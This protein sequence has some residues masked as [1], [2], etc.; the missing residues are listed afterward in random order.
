M[1]T[2][3][4]LGLTAPFAVY[5][6]VG[7]GA[8]D[9]AY[10]HALAVPRNSGAQNRIPVLGPPT[11]AHHA[12]EAVSTPAPQRSPGQPGTVVV[13]SPPGSAVADIAAAL[14]ESVGG[15]HVEPTDLGGI[16]RACAGARHVALVALAG[17]IGERE[18]AAAQDSLWQE[19]GGG[20]GGH[21]GLLTGVTRAD[22]AWLIAKGL[23]LPHRSAP[24]DPAL[25]VWSALES[26]ERRVSSRVLLAEDSRTSVLRPLL[27]EQRWRDLSLM[28]HGRDDAAIFNDM[29]VCA[30]GPLRLEPDDPER[31]RAPACAFTGRCYRP[32]VEPDQVVKAELIL[33][34]AVFAN[35]CMSLRV[36]DGL[37]PARYLLPHGF[38]R[39]TAAGFIGSPMVVNGSAKLADVFHACSAGG[40]TL[41][42]TATVMN[43][44]LRHERV[45]LP[46]FTMLGLPW[47]RLADPDPAAWDAFAQ[48][49][50]E[51][52]THWG[53]A[54]ATALSLSAETRTGR[55]LVLATSPRS[56]AALAAVPGATAL[57]EVDADDVSDLSA[58]AR[59]L[60]RS[61]TNLDDVPL[62][63]L[64]Y[65][66]HGNVMNNVRAQV[67]SLA[68]ALSRAALAGDIDRLTRRLD[69]VV[70]AVER[71]ELGL[72]EALA[73]RGV[74][75]IQ[76]FNDIWG[77]RFE[78]DEP[79]LSG[80]DCPYCGRALV[81][82][83]AT[84]S[85][86]GRLRRT[87]TICPRCVVVIDSD[88]AS[89]VASARLACEESWSRDS[90]QEV[91]LTFRLGPGHAAGSTV[92]A[93]VFV[94]GAE[95]IG[96]GAAAVE[97]IRPDATGT[98]RLTVKVAVGQEA[99]L[100]QEY[101]RGLVIAEGTVVVVTR[102][103]WVRP[104]ATPVGIGQ[105][106]VTG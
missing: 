24:R 17:E 78:Y 100:H 39:G 70:Q 47:A 6:H 27:T 49:R 54:R 62:L 53:A 76:T 29:V 35:V 71:A 90:S 22:V 12:V 84:H 86:F 50:A 19:F 67:T 74:N 57:P 97:R 105:R 25:R 20:D 43:D 51:A 103:V 26:L 45:D 87:A 44:H 32:G 72:A 101:V 18:L 66:R 10:L 31:E 64:R 2:L 9:D 68:T 56:A 16:G 79:E 89:P 102:P 5:E 15:R 73:E 75:G 55:A 63:G 59:A 94:A 83:R 106:P 77:E 23:G 99:R 85:V 58:R 52:G 34:D 92:A 30:P 3:Q 28:T 41:G 37:F 82:Q 104:A 4:E 98:G 7:Q 88:D 46:S 61:M 48:L 21:L 91:T 13:V 42:E 33:A 1:T 38:V 11:A 81:W 96:I 93:A 95:K 40:L 14:A 36:S 60:G 8:D 80:E 69:T 65:S